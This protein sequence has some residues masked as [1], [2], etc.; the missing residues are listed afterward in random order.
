MGRL[1][2]A[3]DAGDESLGRAPRPARRPIGQR[4]AHSDAL[5]LSELGARQPALSRA[6]TSITKAAR[7]SLVGLARRPG[8]RQACRPYVR[9]VSAE[10]PTFAAIISIVTVIGCSA[11]K[12]R[13]NSGDRGGVWFRGSGGESWPTTAV[14][15]QSAWRDGHRPARTPSRAVCSRLGG[16]RQSRVFHGESAQ[17]SSG[18]NH[19]QL[20]CQRKKGRSEAMRMMHAAAATPIRR[21]SLR[22]RRNK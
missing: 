21:R 10:Q 12:R 13:E 22:K 15:R 11:D 3:A 6:K 18:V 17:R 5:A 14:Q 8:S 7:S 4:V 16:V 9:S 2:A 20:A 19:S 1:E